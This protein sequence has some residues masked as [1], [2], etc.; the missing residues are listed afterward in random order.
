MKFLFQAKNAIGELREGKIEA[1]DSDA[2]AA[3]L[4]EKGLLPLSIKK[5]QEISGII[6][7][8]QHLWNGVKARELAVFFRQLSTLLE[9]KVAI[10]S[11]LQA[12]GE[13]TDNEYLK[14]IIREMIG[15]IEDGASLAEAMAKHYEIFESLTISMVKAGE[16]SG[17][18][19][20]SISFL[21]DNTEKNCEFNSKIKSAMFYPAFVLSATLIIGF[22]VFTFVLPKLTSIFKE[23]NVTIPWYTK[24]L[25]AVGDFMSVYWWIVILVVTFLVVATVYYAKT[26]EGKKEL[27][28]LKIKMPIFGSL[29][30]Y[31]YISRFA[32]NLSV[33]LDGGIPIVRALIIVS[34]V[35]NN[36]AYE[37]IILRAA[38]EVKTGGAMSNVFARSAQFPP[39]VSQMIKIGEDTGKISEVL[40]NVSTFYG[41][42]TD[43]IT[44]NLSTMVEPVL[45]IVLGLG[46]AILVF[47]ILVPIYNIS[48][49]MQ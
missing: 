35:V 15:D 36:V 47:S 48:G 28:L 42:E 14:T 24:A 5:E 31:V 4:Q 27:D 26:E 7:D 46:V 16:I 40:K 44:R 10:I 23:M 43:R 45:M 12:T 41:K 11:A 39:I 6:K 8:V 17:N 3:M 22:I 38:D 20:R 25:M 49:S 29:F 21:A 34:E 1:V 9:A 32:E 13:Q 18:L 30:R 37:S 2:A 19:Q 33:L